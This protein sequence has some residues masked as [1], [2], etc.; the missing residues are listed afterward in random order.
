M[1]SRRLVAC[2][3]S[4]GCI[5]SLRVAEMMGS[6]HMSHVRCRSINCLDSEALCA[7]P[8]GY[9]LAPISPLQAVKKLT[10][11]VVGILLHT[12]ISHRL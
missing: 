10:A 6:M 1:V 3:A 11:E 9:E 7:C 5:A 8:G 4:S 2:V 12:H